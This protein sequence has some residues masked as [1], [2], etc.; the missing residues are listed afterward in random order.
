MNPFL[1]IL[2]EFGLRH[3]SDYSKGAKRIDYYVPDHH[4]KSGIQVVT[5]LRKG[6]PY[7]FEWRGSGMSGGSTAEGL[8]QYLEQDRSKYE[9]MVERHRTGTGEFGPGKHN[10]GKIFFASDDPNDADKTHAFRAKGLSEAKRKVQMMREQTGRDLDLFGWSGKEI[11]PGT[12]WF[13]RCLEG[14]KRSGSAVDPGAVCG[15]QLKRMGYRRCNPWIQDE[16]DVFDVIEEAKDAWFKKHPE[17]DVETTF[18]TDEFINKSLGLPPGGSTRPLADQFADWTARQIKFGVQRGLS[19]WWRSIEQGRQRNQEA[20]KG[21]SHNR[22]TRNAGPPTSTSSWA[23]HGVGG[24]AWDSDIG[25]YTI[26]PV[27]RRGRTVYQLHSPAGSRGR[28]YS[29][30]R[31]LEA[32]IKQA[33]SNY[34][35]V[36]GK[37]RSNPKVQGIAGWTM[38]AGGTSA[39][40]GKHSYDL[41]IAPGNLAGGQRQYSIH[42]ISSQ[43][44]RHKGYHLSVAG[45]PEYSGLHHDLGMFRS[46]QSAASAARKHYSGSGG[47]SKSNSRRRG[48]S[49]NPIKHYQIRKVGRVFTVSAK[50]RNAAQAEVNKYCRQHGL[51]KRNAGPGYKV[52][53][54]RGRRSVSNPHHLKGWTAIR[55]AEKHGGTLKKYNDPIERA[56][57]RVSIA[58]AKDV[59]REDPALIYMDIPSGS[60]KRRH[61]NRRSASMLIPRSTRHSIKAVER[62]TSQALSRY[63]G[64]GSTSGR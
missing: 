27:G 29:E 42:P 39:A 38:Y 52:S 54:R 11:N 59:A 9:A 40:P 60:K 19:D 47:E 49:R 15:A 4:W 22:R 64:K 44:G 30:H 56:L 5:H 2:D 55:Y 23:Y 3:S 57:S 63:L 24:Y 8:R 12:G 32:A 33:R 16:S 50:T 7:K 61:R 43:Y 48:R 58:K 37:R 41:Y 53:M 36:K 21:R 45:S 17:V 28:A 13:T 31:T 18:E 10:P 20:V 26:D 1:S 35:T 46:P 62:R 25:K 14:V 34:M 51:I 6:E